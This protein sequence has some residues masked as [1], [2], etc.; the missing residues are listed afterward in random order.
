MQG[1]K[2]KKRRCTDNKQRVNE[3]S[4]GDVNKHR[5]LT[6]ARTNKA[7]EAFEGGAEA[8]EAGLPGLVL[9]PVGGCGGSGKG[10]KTQGV[11]VDLGVQWSVLVVGSVMGTV[12]GG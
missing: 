2:T 10:A 3:C 9:I 1:K 12:A 6:V 8:L 7:K 5:R 4:R 11:G